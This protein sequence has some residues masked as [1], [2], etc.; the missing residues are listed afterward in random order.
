MSVQDE[1]KKSRLTLTY[2]TTVDG[3]PKSVDL[4]FRLLVL[5]DFSSGTSK[6]RKKPLDERSQRSLDGSNFD[7]VMKDMEISVDMVVPN[8][9]SPDEESLRVTLPIDSMNSFSPKEVAN[10]IP[11]VR[12]L[13]LLKK[14]LE[15]LQ[16]NVAN[17]KEF[18]QLL[19][20]LY[21]SEESLT[22]MREKLQQY[23]PEYT[24]SYDAE[25]ENNNGGE[26]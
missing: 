16:S 6:D 23:A 17:K 13:L 12:S 22:K 3:E 5:G 1:V 25:N 15:E 19:N 9:L 11:Q 10:S 24:I 18:A 8:Q 2:K 7:N 20:K 26:E 14:L 21:S 4:P